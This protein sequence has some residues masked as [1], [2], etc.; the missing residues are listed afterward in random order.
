MKVLT[1]I[2]Q[3]RFSVDQLII[4]AMLPAGRRAG[5]ALTDGMKRFIGR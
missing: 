4:V 3:I 1:Q 5:E 2:P